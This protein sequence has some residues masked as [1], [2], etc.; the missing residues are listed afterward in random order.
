MFLSGTA[1][2]EYDYQSSQSDFE[3]FNDNPIDVETLLT[4]YGISLNKFDFGVVVGAGVEYALSSFV[5]NLE[6]RYSLGFIDVT[7]DNWFSN[8]VITFTAGAGYR[9]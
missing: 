5:I 7:D 3:S 8:S 9:F 4:A 2:N 1:Y 6:A